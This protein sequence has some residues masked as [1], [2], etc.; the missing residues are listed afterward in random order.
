MVVENYMIKTDRLLN[1]NVIVYEEPQ[2]LSMC[3]DYECLCDE[4]KEYI[5][6]CFYIDLK[7]KLNS[8][9]TRITIVAFN[10]FDKELRFFEI[11]TEPFTDEL[12][13]DTD[14]TKVWLDDEEGDRLI[15]IMKSNL[16]DVLNT[17]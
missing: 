10:I 6:N 9:N 16:L 4:V 14:I 5:N 11:I 3:V 7:E 2:I 15:T 12:E 13:S 8:D 17:I 1:D